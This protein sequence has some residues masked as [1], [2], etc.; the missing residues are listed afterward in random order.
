MKTKLLPFAAMLAMA[1]LSAC[2]AHHG[3][4][5]DPRFKETT[6]RPDLD[7]KQSNYGKPGFQEALP[8]TDTIAGDSTLSAP[9]K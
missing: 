3:A 2:D 8:V 7:T 4:A 9:K 1:M 6:P 5:D